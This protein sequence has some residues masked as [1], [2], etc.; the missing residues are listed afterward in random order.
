MT[1][2]G[3]APAGP[4]R[5]AGRLHCGWLVPG[6]GGRHARGDDCVYYQYVQRFGNFF[7]RLSYVM[8]KSK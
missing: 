8:G 2:V 7:G 4:A 1:P 6:E 5:S 3:R